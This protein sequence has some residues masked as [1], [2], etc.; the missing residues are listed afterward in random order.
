M[1]P[2]IAL[3]ALP[4][5]AGA[6]GAAGAAGGGG[7]MSMLGGL[8]GSGAGGKAAM[9]GITGII[10][11][12]QAKNI[13]KKADAALPPAID[14][15]QAA[16]LS[17]LNQ[18][19]KAIDTGA[20]FNTGMNAVNATNAAT[21]DAIVKSTGGDAGGTIAGL[22][23]SERAAGDGVNNVIATGQN[24]Q[25][26]Y[27]SMFNDLNNKISARALQLQM[28]KS[29]QARAEATQ[30]QQTANQNLMGALGNVPKSN[31]AQPGAAGSFL[32][33]DSSVPLTP[34]LTPPTL[35]PPTNPDD[36][37]LKGNGGKIDTSFLY[38]LR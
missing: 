3:A 18:K 5:I 26:Q 36:L 8:G 20:E 33:G 2:A 37:Q 25:M 13:K 34:N 23:K 17:E 29:L 10:Q 30:K 22:L 4:E 28:Y 14:P 31:D 35:S 15:R 21:N 38:N 16:F 24:Q 27:N 7:I 1:P 32:G 11:A 6:S 9:S 12:I 19:R